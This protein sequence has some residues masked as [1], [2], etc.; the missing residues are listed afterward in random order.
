MTTLQSRLTTAVFATLLVVGLVAAAV[1]Y[2]SAA[3][4]AR[5]M[6]DDELR[7]VAHLAAVSIGYVSQPGYRATAGIGDPE[8]E[9]VVAVYGPRGLVFA[10]RGRPL[11]SE[12]GFLGIGQEPVGDQPYR[13]Y[14]LKDGARTVV[15]GLQIEVRDELALDAAGSAALPVLLAI[16]ILALVLTWVIR[17]ALRPLTKA[18][19]SVAR[20]PSDALAPLALDDLPA[21]VEPFVAEIDR[22]M[23][24]LAVTLETERSFLADTAHALRT[25]V[26]ALQLQADVLASARDPDAQR[27]RAAELQAGVRRIARLVS[28]L[29]DWVKRDAPVNAQAECEIVSVLRA[30]VELYQDAAAAAR[31]RVELHAEQ[32][33]RCR[34]AATDLAIAFGNLLDNAIR[35]SPPG[36]S[37]AVL[38]SANSTDVRVEI[39]DEGPGLP[40]GELE[41]V[42]E[43]FYQGA[44]AAG[45]AGLGLATARRIVERLTGSITLSNRAGGGLIAQVA[46][47]RRPTGPG[48]L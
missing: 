45:G 31:V 5:E 34:G 14:R 9:I 1:S 37:V 10:T 21:E 41:R 38:I 40:V 47:P 39:H 22:L 30:V 8:D 46:L 16:P 7:Q 28:Q 33:I 4:D 32:P 2:W 11:P 26:A 18:A 12:H 48:M 27:V 15:V 24:R 3:G 6:L 17:R 29:L 13:I 23:G 42:F 35:H 36:R 43:R 25:P 19:D 20:R 44:T